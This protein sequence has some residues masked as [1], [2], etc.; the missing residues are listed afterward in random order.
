M[1]TRA[2]AGRDFM[3][4]GRSAALS[5]RGM[6][7]TSHATASLTAVEILKAGGNAVDAAIAAVAV[8]CVV[9]PHMTGIGGDC[10]V[11]YGPAGGTPVALN[12]SGRAPAAA[13][14]EW[15]VEQGF[16]AIPNQSAHAV[17]IPGAIAAWCRLS[18]DY[19]RL[20]LQETLRPAIAAARD[21][22]LVTQ[23][24]AADWALYGPRLKGE[25]AAAFMPGGK[26]PVFGDRLT[27]PAL[28]QTLESVAVSGRSAFYEGAVAEEMVAVLNSL[29]GL[30]TPDDFATA[31]ADY[32]APIRADYRG[33]T[34][35]ECPPNGQGLAALMMARVLDR[36]DLS[37]AG[38][39]EADRIHL[40]AEATKAVYAQREALISD[41]DF[42]TLDFQQGLDPAFIDRLAGSIDPVRART[43]IKSHFPVHRDTVQISVVDRD[44]NAVSLI[45]SIYSAFGS[46][47]HAS[48][49][50]VLLQDRGAGFSVSPAHPNAIA[51]RKRPF[52]TII[53]ALLAEREKTVMAF[54]VV[55]AQYQAVG[56]IQVL[57]GVVDRGLDIQQACDVPRSFAYDG[58]LSLETTI[59]PS[60]AENL[61]RRGHVVEWAQEAIGGCQAVWIDHARGI[62][63]G[64]ADQRKDGIAL[65]I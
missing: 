11:L 18:Q 51:P 36:F 20:S 48:R 5:D 63:H 15:Y 31:T 39:S 40:L 27:N 25:A 49:S 54:G 45:N 52:H 60:V 14:A 16:A 4:P 42:A 43:T 22:Y 62:L 6:V 58:K 44:G 30:H 23:R 17:T 47:I 3:L 7:S 61:G 19:G 28:A 10:F 2:S 35:F 37:S 8:Q 65:G 38:M 50:G 21:G 56:Q 64:A 33:Y 46:G 59:N 57:S 13:D 34:L 29:G 53:P 1:P 41:P 32:V 12:G 24:T 55:G 9:E 26:A